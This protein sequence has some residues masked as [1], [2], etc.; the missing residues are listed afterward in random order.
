MHTQIFFFKNQSIHTLLQP[1]FSIQFIMNISHIFLHCHLLC[2][3]LYIEQMH[4]FALLSLPNLRPETCFSISA[5][6]PTSFPTTTPRCLLA[7][8][9]CTMVGRKKEMP[10]EW[11][12]RM[13]SMGRWRLLNQRGWGTQSY[14][15]ML[16]GKGQPMLW[17][18]FRGF[19]D[20]SIVSFFLK[21]K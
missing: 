13:H 18:Q 9:N 6:I 19:P 7:Q 17:E 20:R 5:W 12:M 1:T 10:G 3:L 2:S 11:R 16:L 8:S 4:V 15:K 14:V 21:S